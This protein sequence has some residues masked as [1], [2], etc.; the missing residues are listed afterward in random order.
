MPMTCHTVAAD[1]TC[2]HKIRS[3]FCQ[4]DKAV[5]GLR[6]MTLTEASSP[7]HAQR[8]D[9]ASAKDGRNQWPRQELSAWRGAFRQR[10]RRTWC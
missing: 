9:C 1:C 2:S 6:L 3:I 10:S 8:L 7:V 4:H 5:Q